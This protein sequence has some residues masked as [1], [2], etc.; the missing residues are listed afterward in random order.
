MD[1]KYTSSGSSNQETGFDAG[2]FQ[3][4]LGEGVGFRVGVGARDTVTVDGEGISVGVGV[5]NDDENADLD[6]MLVDQDDEEEE[7]DQRGEDDQS[8]DGE[9]D[10]NG[11]VIT[12]ATAKAAHELIARV[13]AEVGTGMKRDDMGEEVEDPPHL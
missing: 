13:A 2:S 10:A 9:G 3:E 8:D 1:Y 11:K 6:S 4:M 5:E 12:M 7:E